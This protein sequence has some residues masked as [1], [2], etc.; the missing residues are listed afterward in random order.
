MPS[1]LHKRAEP[2]FHTAASRARWKNP[3]GVTFD[4]AAKDTFLDFLSYHGKP[5]IACQ[6]VGITKYVYQNHL[7]AD[8]DFAAKVDEVIG[9]LNETRAHQIET[10]ALTGSE[11]ITYNGRGEEVGRQKVYETKLREM[12]LKRSDP[13]YREHISIDASVSGGCLVIP[14]VVSLEDWEQN[15]SG[16]IIAK[17]NEQLK[18]GSG[19]D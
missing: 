12:I 18:E 9:H 19:E 5:M 15:F 7:K 1:D 17:Q 4:D 3:R 8:P 16:Q 11:R 10:E 6:E 13:A 2:V 14:A